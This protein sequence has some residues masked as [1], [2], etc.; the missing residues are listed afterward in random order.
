[1]FVGVQVTNG[2][3][4]HYHISVASLKPSRSL[5]VVYI[6]ENSSIHRISKSP[7]IHG[8]FWSTMDAISIL[9]LA[10]LLT[11][12]IQGS[13]PILHKQIQWRVNISGDARNG[14]ATSHIHTREV[15]A[16]TVIDFLSGFLVSHLSRNNFSHEKFTT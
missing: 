9:L 14:P 11:L 4:P 16:V 15:K 10:S 7:D 5:Q 2:F 12:N 13:Q 6:K 1:M 3:Y 8:A